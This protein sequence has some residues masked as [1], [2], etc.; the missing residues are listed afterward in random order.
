MLS[1]L[2]VCLPQ[3]ALSRFAGWLANS[4]NPWLKN[5]LIA[6]FIRNHPADLSEALV[7]DPF[8]YPSFNAL[9][10][11]RLNPHFRPITT[12]LNDF[13]SPA[14]GE[15]YALGK[16]E[17]GTLLQA[18]GRP[19]RVQDLLG[20]DESLAA[21]F[22]NGRYLTIYLA[23]HD[24]HRVHMPVDGHLSEMIYVPGNLFSVNRK[25]ARFIPNLFARNERVICI[26]NTPKGRVA[27]IL[28]GAMIAGSIETVWAGTVTPRS[29][30]SI[31]KFNY[32]NGIFLRRGEEMG[33]FK[34]GSTVIVLTES[35]TL[36]FELSLESGSKVMMGEK[37]GE[38][39]NTPHI[40]HDHLAAF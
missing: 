32:D 36:A 35:Q 27:V 21:L 13:A 38:Y 10:T 9:F 2:Q 40:L 11:R 30:R 23:P 22:S 20:G 7:T 19:Y 37:L 15:V 16:L 1:W 39:V 14:D 28:V 12:G 5:Q 31:L 29:S 25:T 24:Y 34:F 3:H 33:R 8:Q 26:F 4:E 6:Y 17:D 18:K